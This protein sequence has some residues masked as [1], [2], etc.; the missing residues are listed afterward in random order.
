MRRAPILL[1]ALTLAGAPLA[2]AATE[3]PGPQG[4]RISFAGK[5]AKLSGFLATPA[6]KG[7]HP[8][9]V[10]IHEW[11][12]LNDWIRDNTREMAR[13]G[14]VALAVDLY[15]GQ[16]AED[17]DTAH[18]L[19]RGLPSDRALADLKAAVAYVRGRDD[20]DGDRVGSIGW[21]FGGGH[22]LAL[23]LAEPLQATVVCYGRLVLDPET[24][25]SLAGPVLGVFGENDRGIPPDDVR[26]FEKSLGEAGVD[27]DVALYEDVGH[28]FMN[29]GNERG[30]SEAAAGE[31]WK[32]IFGFLD[33]QLGK[34]RDD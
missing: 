30:Y 5:D 28:A 24:L 18:E 25:R 29:P 4:A 14:Y 13:R 31:A 15:R 8:A 6:G 11:W 9:M 3:D 10:V 7:P 2:W 34:R 33:E 20:V 27:A 19:S 26:Q 23:S 1:M 21:C 16:V 12:G 22:S 17:R 32:R